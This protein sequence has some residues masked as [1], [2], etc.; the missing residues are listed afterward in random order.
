MLPH[1]RTS[2]PQPTP[3]RNTPFLVHNPSNTSFLPLSPHGFVLHP[4]LMF[5][6]EFLPV[7]QRNALLLLSASQM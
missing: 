1:T 3:F 6:V 5:E 4:A 2:V 7:L